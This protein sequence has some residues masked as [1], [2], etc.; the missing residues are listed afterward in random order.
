MYIQIP[1][2]YIGSTKPHEFETYGLNI[3]NLKFEKVNSDLPEG[4]RRV[5]LEIL[6]NAGDNCD[7]SRRANVDPDK[8]IN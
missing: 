7:A 3:E 1:D 2:T 6:S 4:V 5:F 8:I